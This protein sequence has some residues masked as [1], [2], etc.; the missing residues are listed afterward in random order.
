MKLYIILCKS[1]QVVKINKRVFVITSSDCVGQKDGA[2]YL[3]L[4]LILNVCGFIS[5]ENLTDRT[6][7]EMEDSNS[8][9]IFEQQQPMVPVRAG[10]GSM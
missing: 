9:F 8:I 4:G 1:F 6:V 2:R 10:L 3:L 5:R 7:N